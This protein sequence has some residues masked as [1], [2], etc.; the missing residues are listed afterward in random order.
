MIVAIS[1]PKDRS[2]AVVLSRITRSST[3]GKH[4]RPIVAML[5]LMHAAL[6]AWGAGRHSPTFDEPPHLA[7][8][9][10]HWQFGRFELYRVNPPLVRMVAAL[11]VLAVGAKSDWTEFYERPG[12]R[13]V[14]QIGKEFVAANGQRSFWLFTLARWACIP[15]SLLGG[16]ICFRW[17]RELY[18]DLAGFLALSLWCFSPNIIAHGQLITPDVAATALGVTAAYVFWKWLKAPVWSR[19][20]LAGLVLGLAELAKMTW[21]ILFGLWPLLWFFWNCSHADTRLSWRTWRRQTPQLIGILV[22]ALYVLNLGYGFDGSFR[23]LQDFQF[24][25]Q[26][27]SGA[28]LVSY[29]N[30]NRFADSWLGAVPVPFPKN[31]LLGMDVQKRDF[32]SF[33]RPSY[34]RGEFRD[35]GWWYYYLYAAAVKVPLG[36]WLLL[37]LVLVILGRQAT[38]TKW[39]DHTILLL[40]AVAVF[41]LVSS[42]TVF[43]HHFRYVLPVFPF[44]FIAIS[45]VASAAI[46]RGRKTALVTAA[47]LLWSVGSSLWVYPHSLSYFNELAGGPSGGHA[48]LI[49]SN[50]DW[51]Q[52]L[53]YL[54]RWLDEHPEA[55]P[56]HL[57]YYGCFDPAVVGIEYTLPPAASSDDND[58]SEP[59]LFQPGWYAVSVNF[60]RG[61]PWPAPD[62]RG[63]WVYLEKNAYSDLR[64]F[65]PVTRAGYSIY[66]YHVTESERTRVRHEHD[67]GAN[68]ERK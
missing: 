68:G 60:L 50:I 11:P 7:A 47:A 29:G 22:I 26:T 13:P 66:V 52:D 15:F 56:L 45:R 24:V 51:G 10:S 17:A 3:T 34:L 19:A 63:G 18:G 5:L 40:P 62:G 9:I 59:A 16:Y 12:V 28:E 58:G 42:Q 44:V 49:H 46:A 53:L 4:V 20:L 14:F 67:P 27:L 8:G 23:K 30:G 6:L 21:I 61:Y 65:R 33:S 1:R 35:R 37:L 25:S 31:Y 64:G 54:K 39:Q 2:A 38:P 57:A 43:S 32:E 55:R 36:T 48:H 41:S